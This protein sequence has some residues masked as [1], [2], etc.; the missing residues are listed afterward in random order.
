MY[1]VAFSFTYN[2]VSGWLVHVHNHL[3]TKVVAN[4]LANDKR[5][6]EQ[7]LDAGKEFSWYVGFNLVKEGDKGQFMFSD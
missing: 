1:G 4:V 6:S 3:T 5:I 7:I 2:A